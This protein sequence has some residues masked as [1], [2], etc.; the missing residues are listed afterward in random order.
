M[1]LACRTRRRSE[2]RIAGTP[3]SYALVRRELWARD[4]HRTERECARSA[5]STARR[6]KR[7]MISLCNT[8]CA[9]LSRHAQ[10]VLSHGE[11]VHRADSSLLTPAMRPAAC[12]QRQCAG[13][14][15]QVD[16]G[17][18]CQPAM[19]SCRTMWASTARLRWHEVLRML[20]YR[21]QTA[22]APR[23]P[24]DTVRMNGVAGS[25]KGSETVKPPDLAGATPGESRLPE[26]SC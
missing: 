24:T 5:T 11:S 23:S 22:R 2:P 18:I 14:V 4:F 19:A 13:C 26:R 17:T 12:L 21:F 15:A 10:S 20:R 3:W 25:C 6:T 1:Q 8:D 7:R 16:R 9:G